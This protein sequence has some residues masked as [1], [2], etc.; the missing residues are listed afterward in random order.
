MVVMGVWGKYQCVCFVV[1]DLRC[2]L[3]WLWDFLVPD[4]LSLLSV[5]LDST[6]KSS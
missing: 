6:C 3:D 5:L 1:I 4:T 2:M